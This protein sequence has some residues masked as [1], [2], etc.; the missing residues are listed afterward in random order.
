MCQALL[1][2][3][4]YTAMNKTDIVSA[5]GVGGGAGVLV[6]GDIKQI[7]IQL[8]YQVMISAIKMGEGYLLNSSNGKPLR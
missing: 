1:L 7:N 5:F 6:G 4:G 2:G 8:I 3:T